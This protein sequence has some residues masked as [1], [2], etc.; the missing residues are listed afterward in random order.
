M[1]RNIFLSIILF[2]FIQCGNNKE[3]KF[4]GGFEGGTYHSIANS[5]KNLPEW[6]VEIVKSNGS[7]ENIQLIK[8]G[9]VDFGLVQ[10]DMYKSAKISDPSIAEKL[11]PITPIL[12]D[13]VHLVV[14]KEI[15]SIEDL[16]GKKILIGHSE[17][18]IKATSLTVLREIGI[19]DSD[20]TFIE[21]NPTL[22]FKKIFTNEID[23]AFI[24]SGMPVKIL[25]EVSD[26]DGKK[27]KLLDL[28]KIFETKLSKGN[29]V[30]SL[31]EIPKGTYKWETDV[32]ETLLVQT[33]L[34]AN[35]KVNPTKIKNLIESILKNK[36]T[37]EVGHPEWK[38]FSHNFI[39]KEKKNNP[40][41]VF[42]S[43]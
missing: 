22:G 27:I 7:F 36:M 9:K 19:T 15:K 17:S 6:K 18:G 13:E 34:F 4:A 32:T 33:V 37:L 23:A 30:Y 41:M 25:T 35:Q 42:P 5:L 3:M 12:K 39:Q 26:E 40:E 24:V 43:L 14:R 2:T 29:K 21:E 8:E 10:L 31:G 1:F 11:I 20:S 28:K 16:K 38:D